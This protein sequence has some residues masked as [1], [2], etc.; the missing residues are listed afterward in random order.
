MCRKLVLSGWVLLISEKAEQARVLVALF[1]SIAFLAMRFSLRPLK[2]CATLP[3]QAQSSSVALAPLCCPLC[4]SEDAVL[5]TLND[6]VLAVAVSVC[7]SSRLA[8]CCRTPAAASASATPPKVR[9]WPFVLLP[10]VV[11]L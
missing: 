9:L 6:L 5:A 4:R 10:Q 7:W 8:I 2:R 1:V 11:R 3:T